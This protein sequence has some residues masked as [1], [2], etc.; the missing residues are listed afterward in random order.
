MMVVSGNSSEKSEL[1]GIL[2]QV[3][4]ESRIGLAP[5]KGAVAPKAEEVQRV[6]QT[7]AQPGQPGESIRCVVSV[8]M[9][10][11]GWDCQ[12]VTQ[13]LG[14]RKFGSQLLCEQ[15]LG[16]ALRRSNHESRTIV[17]K[18]GTGRETERFLPEYA[19]VLGVPFNTVPAEGEGTHVPLPSSYE[20]KPSEKPEFRIEYPRF[21]RYGIETDHGRLLLDE[22]RMGNLVFPDISPERKSTRLEGAFGSGENREA[23]K[24]ECDGEWLLACDLARFAWR[25]NLLG[26]PDEGTKRKS[27]PFGQ[28]ASLFADARDIVRKWTTTRPMWK[29]VLHAPEARE[30]LLTAFSKG[31]TAK[32]TIP[33]KIGIP[34]ERGEPFASASDWSPFRSR[35]QN[36][37]VMRKSELNVAACHSAL[38]IRVVEA[39]ENWDG[40]QAI[41]RNHGEESLRIPYRYRDSWSMYVP[42]FLVRLN[43]KTDRGGTVHVIVEGKGVS[44][45]ISEAKKLWTRAWWCEVANRFEEERRS[46]NRWIHVEIGPRDD[47]VETVKKEV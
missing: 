5:A 20:V 13:I 15:T 12:R 47:A 6:L 22:S 40:V 32:G 21:L 33:R 24:V 23:E 45:D 9:L 29:D 14:Y 39:L 43:R 16:R 8:G 7:V 3:K 1:G 46:G 18:S 38:E 42:D 26:Q 28:P 2:D 25:Q 10:T 36:S 4:R 19:T 11:E 30:A 41:T 37:R 17:R 34:Y 31:L 27:K 44:D 35:L